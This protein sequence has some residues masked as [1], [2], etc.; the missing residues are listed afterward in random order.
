MCSKPRS[1]PKRVTFEL[2]NE[3]VDAAVST[4]AESEQRATLEN[5]NASRC[6]IQEKPNTLKK[7]TAVKKVFVRHTELEL[8]S[9]KVVSKIPEEVQLSESI[10]SS[11]DAA[12]AYKARYAVPELFSALCIAKE[13]QER[14]EPKSMKCA[15]VPAAVKHI[16]EGKASSKLNFYPEEQIFKDLVN[17]NVN[18]EMLLGAAEERTTTWKLPKDEEPKLSDFYQPKFVGEYTSASEPSLS[19]IG[20]IRNYNG[21]STYKRRMAWTITDVP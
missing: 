8:P 20:K 19:A 6:I 13:F 9:S 7:S 11:L 12:S 10:E 1:P 3:N 15:P 18:E 5:A 16:M 17:L 14:K 4:F 21:F 2:P